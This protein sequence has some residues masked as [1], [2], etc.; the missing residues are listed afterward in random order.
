MVDNLAEK[1]TNVF[2]QNF[3]LCPHNTNMSYDEWRVKLW[4]EALPRSY[5]SLAN[6][7]YK[8]WL[9]LRYD[10][11]FLPPGVKSLLIYLRNNYLLGLITNGSSSSQWEKVEQLKLNQYFDCILVSGD[12]PWEKPHQN[13]FLKAC[14]ILKVKPEDCLMVGDRLETDIAGAKEASL[15]GAVWIPNSVKQTEEHY[16]STPDYILT[17]VTQLKDLL[18]SHIKS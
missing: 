14:Q 9:K 12:L 17:S 18:C 5:V 2:L 8:E 16:K 11:V 1:A 13:I 15:A 6:E 7:I 4:E 3:R 10:Y